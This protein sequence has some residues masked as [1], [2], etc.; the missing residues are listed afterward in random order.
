MGATRGWR[1]RNRPRRVGGEG[2]T[3][4]P[5]E[6]L[7]EAS[8]PVRTGVRKRRFGGHGK[9]WR[10]ELLAAS[11]KFAFGLQPIL[12]FGSGRCATLEENLVSTLRDLFFRGTKCCAN[13]FFGGW[14]FLK[15]GGL[16]GHTF[17]Q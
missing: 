12:E 1:G 11:S 14:W 8:L 3:N 7:N 5:R 6:R 16:A 2:R 10:N 17:L 13:G 15:S 4:A 9:L